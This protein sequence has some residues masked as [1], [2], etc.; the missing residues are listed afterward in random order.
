VSVKVMSAVIDRYPVGGSEMLL[1]LVLADVARD[2]GRLMIV[3][4]VAELARKTRQTDRGVQRQLGRMER[5]GWLRVTRA[6]DGDKGRASTFSINA[7]WINGGEL[8]AHPVALNG[9]ARPG[10]GSRAK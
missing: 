8:Q 5:C 9:A 4:S 2:D 6:S 10:C 7:D 1:A 3:D